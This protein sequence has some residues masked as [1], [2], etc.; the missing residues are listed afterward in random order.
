MYNYA[1]YVL[2]CS[3][4]LGVIFNL[5]YFCEICFIIFSRGC[6]G[7]LYVTDECNATSQNAV[8]AEMSQTQIHLKTVQA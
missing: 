4:D 2:F 7:R 1:K 5:I 6:C 3:F 8:Q